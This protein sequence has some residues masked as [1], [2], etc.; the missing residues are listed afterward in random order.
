VTI[1]HQVS[2][3]SWLCGTDGE[4]WPCESARKLLSEAY[5]GEPDRLVRYLAHFMAQAATDLGV[6]G[7]AL[8]YRRFMGWTLGPGEVCRVCGRSSHTVVTGLPPRLLPC[9]GIRAV[10]SLD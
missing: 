2:R 6:P 5:R 7:P 8:L 4:A 9:D 1:E 3:P 10:P